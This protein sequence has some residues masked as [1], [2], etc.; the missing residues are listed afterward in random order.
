MTFY[1]KYTRML[2]VAHFCHFLLANIGQYHVK[3]VAKGVCIVSH[4]TNSHKSE[5]DSLFLNDAT[6]C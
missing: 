2:T 4:C 6:D 1:S 5:L 3:A